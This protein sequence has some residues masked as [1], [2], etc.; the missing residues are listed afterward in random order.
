[1]LIGFVLGAF[2]GATIATVMVAACAAGPR[3]GD[4]R[5]WDVIIENGNGRVNAS[6]R[7]RVLAARRAQEREFFV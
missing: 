7:A 3:D 6:H 1:M 4:E 2:F 5:Q